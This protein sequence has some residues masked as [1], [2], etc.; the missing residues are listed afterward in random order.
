MWNKD[1]CSVVMPSEDTKILQLDQYRKS[2]KTRCTIYVDLESLIKKVDECKNNPGKLFITKV[3]EHI[4]WGYLMSTIWSCDGTENKHDL[5]RDEDCMK[6]FF[7]SFREH[8]MKTINILTGI[9]WKE[10]NLL[11]LQENVW[12]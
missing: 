4:P 8:A 3:G 9:V 12:T 7:E 2:E 6:N 11:Y 5:Y 1:F 10:K